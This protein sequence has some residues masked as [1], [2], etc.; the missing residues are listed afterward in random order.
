[1][2]LSRVWGIIRIKDKIAFDAVVELALCDLDDAL[3]ALCHTLDIPR[4]VVLRK[5]RSEF[6][7]FMRTHFN[8]DDFMESVGFARFE[9]EVLR[10]RKKK[11]AILASSDV[12]D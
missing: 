1:M 11:D 3:E 2:F 7:K 10:D 12:Y 8:P 6:Q 5:H 9:V 4:P